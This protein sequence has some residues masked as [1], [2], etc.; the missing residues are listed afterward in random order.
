MRAGRGNQDRT[1]LCCCS[2]AGR[3]QSQEGWG[4]GWADGHTERRVPQ[5]SNS[6]PSWEMSY[7]YL[8]SPRTEGVKKRELSLGLRG[9]EGGDQ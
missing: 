9:E 4:C 6:S 1:E 5:M 8:T 7:S 3:R 2:G